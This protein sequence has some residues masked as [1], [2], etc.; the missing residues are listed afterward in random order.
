MKLTFCLFSFTYCI[1]IIEPWSESNDLGEMVAW[2]LAGQ[3]NGIV[4]VEKLKRHFIFKKSYKTRF[5]G[6]TS[7]F[8]LPLLEIN[9]I[10]SKSRYTW[11]WFSSERFFKKSF[12]RFMWSYCPNLVNRCELVGFFK[13]SVP[14]F[15]TFISLSYENTEQKNVYP[16]I[17]KNIL[18]CQRWHINWHWIELFFV[19][20][21]IVDDKHFNHFHFEFH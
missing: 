1:D 20:L 9:R 15:S 3:P 16:P 21:F 12:V 5:L 7:H 6:K 13:D 10:A 2:T 8:G 11:R 19:H 4:K 14:S 18:L 17:K